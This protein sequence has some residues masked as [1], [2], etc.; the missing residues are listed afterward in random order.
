MREFI[1]KLEEFELDL[2]DLYRDMVKLQE[3]GFAELVSEL[4]Y[5]VY[6]LIIDLEDES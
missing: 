2:F 3:K 5:E 1:K 4:K 6:R